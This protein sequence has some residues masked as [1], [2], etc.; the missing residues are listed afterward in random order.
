MYEKYAVGEDIKIDNAMTLELGIKRRSLYDIVT[1]LLAW[2]PVY[3]NGL[4]QR[5]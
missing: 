3:W 1:A 2:G 5:E 4:H